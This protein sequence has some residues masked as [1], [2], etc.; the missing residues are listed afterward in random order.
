[1]KDNKVPGSIDEYIFNFPAPVQ[2]SLVKLKATIKE[3]AP[4]AEEK[5]SYQMPL[6]KLKGVL[7]YF[8]VH[9]NHI[10]FYPGPSAIAAFKEE[11]SGYHTSKGTIQFPLGKPLPY[12]LIS[13]II[14][15]NLMR[16]LEKDELRRRK[17]KKKN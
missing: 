17:N 12:K 5:I 3:A 11:L 9:S 6:F 13:Q 7:A 8:A 15:F 16:N 10:G 1:M 4:D 14:K 2:D